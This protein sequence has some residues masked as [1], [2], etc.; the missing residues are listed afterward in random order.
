MRQN[1][2]EHLFNVLY[3]QVN[4]EGINNV[5]KWLNFSLSMCL[6]RLQNMQVNHIVILGVGVDSLE[7]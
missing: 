5:G 6:Y 3:V 2:Y 1:G 7:T 4:L